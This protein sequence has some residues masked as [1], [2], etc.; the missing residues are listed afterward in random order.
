MMGD[1]GH[2]NMRN[3]TKGVAPAFGRVRTLG[4]YVAQPGLELCSRSSV[5]LNF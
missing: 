4:S 5:A 1:G 3:S 2:H